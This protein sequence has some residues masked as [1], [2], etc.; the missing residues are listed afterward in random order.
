[1]SLNSGIAP[2]ELPVLPS[3]KG[4]AMAV[5]WD[6][7]A[8]VADYLPIVQSDPSLTASVLRAANATF[9]PPTLPMLTAEDALT[10]IGVE[11]A[12]EIVAAACTRSEYE[13][14]ARS[15]VHLDDFWSWQLAVGLLTECLAL[16]DDAPAE[17]RRAAFT[18]G[19][20]HQVGRLALMVRSPDR[21]REVVEAVHSGTDPL[22]AEW[23]LLSSDSANIV[24][25]VA[26]H[27]G[28]SEPLPAAL[29]SYASLD[30]T[31]SAARVAEARVV[32]AQLGFSEGY[33]LDVPVLRPLPADHPRAAA[34]EAVGGFAELTR[35]IESLQSLESARTPLMLTTGGDARAQSDGER[36]AS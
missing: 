19:L 35:Q 18:A 15:D 6:A 26:L 5:L 31:G 12:K 27:W 13:D 32:A 9:V 17:E 4:R 16:A 25:L 33:S 36:L 23:Q 29:S 3:L 10:Q 21:Y 11:A 8:D 1:M 14:L 7:D 34:L 22:D 28:L 20:M 2:A 24:G 30:P